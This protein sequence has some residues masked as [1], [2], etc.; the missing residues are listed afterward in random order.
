MR[1]KLKNLAAIS[2]IVGA[3]AIVVTLIVLI[4]ETRENTAAT[5]SST[6]DQLQ[7][8]LI[9]WEMTLASD[10]DLFSEY[11]AFNQLESVEGP[12]EASPA[13]LVSSA[14]FRIAERAY[15]A[16]RYGRLADEEW[17]RW[18]RQMCTAGYAARRRW[19]NTERGIFTNEF[20]QFLDTCE[21]ATSDPAH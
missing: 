10:P 16:H 17:D 21:I 18:Y 12:I 4:H 2:E 14:W 7:R 1:A 13:G 15:F 19:P 5:Y 20:A 11:L 9:Q 6:Y 8:D 3:V